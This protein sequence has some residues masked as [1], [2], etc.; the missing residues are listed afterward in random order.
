[1]KATVFGASGFV[2]R[3]LV[4]HLEAQGRVVRA[5][6][7]GD[8]GWRDEDLG[9][10]F[11]CIGLTADFRQRP[12][13]TVDAHVGQLGEVLRRARF[14]SFVYLSSTR[15]YRHAASTDERASITV[16]SFDPN[17]LYDLSKLMGE[18]LCLASGRP[19][20]RIARLSNV[21]GEDDESD[22][23]LPSVIRSAVTRGTV[24]LRTTLDSEKDYVWVG[25]VIHALDRIARHGSE[26][27]YNIAA[28]RNVTNHAII[29]CLQRETGCTVTLAEE[30]TCWSFPPIATHRLSA[31]CGR[32]FRALEEHMPALVRAF[33]Q[34]R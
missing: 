11:Y 34:R 28:G 5:V 9:D 18:S 26:P 22:N 33:T 14:D 21:F 4:R 6:G 32:R 20:M 12:F 3:H 2:G 30:A 16:T 23:F 27:I 1:M 25:D 7:R 15:L 19:N 13:D 24:H 29:E 10:V 31:L 17:Q 8:Q